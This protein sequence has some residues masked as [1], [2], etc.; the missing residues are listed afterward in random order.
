M[1]GLY[2]QMDG[3]VLLTEE[4][5]KEHNKSSLGIKLLFPI[6]G[7]PGI[8]IFIALCIKAQYYNFLSSNFLVDL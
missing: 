1:S 5:F 2:A 7:F 6:L 8:S 4:N 3:L